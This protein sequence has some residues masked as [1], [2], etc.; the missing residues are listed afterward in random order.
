MVGLRRKHA[1]GGC[2][3]GRIGFRG[4]GTI[5]TSSRRLSAPSAAFVL[6]LSLFGLTGCAV[7]LFDTINEMV[8]FA[9]RTDKEPPTVTFTTPSHGAS[10]APVNTKISVTFSE[11]M[12]PATISVSTFS[13]ND[14]ALG[15][16]GTVQYVES[17]KMAVFTPA[18]SLNSILTYTCTVK[19]GA[20]DL[21]GN[22]IEPEYTWI[23]Q[24]GG[25]TDPAG[26]T[27]SS[28]YPANGTPDA[29]INTAVTVT[30]NESID[31]SSVDSSM[32]RLEEAGA[33]PVSGTVTY[34]D[35]SRTV[36]FEPASDL[37]P[38]K[39]HSAVVAAG[40]RDM[41][42]NT[43]APDY[44]WS[45]TT[46]ALSD[47]TPPTIVSFDPGN[48]DVDVGAGENITVDFSEFMNSDTI[49]STTLRVTTG[50]LPVTGTVSYNPSTNR[51]TFDP[52]SNLR[53]FTL[54]TVSVST[55]VKDAAGNPLSSGASWTFMTGSSDDTVTGITATIGKLEQTATDQLTA[56]VDI[57][58]QSGV[59]VPGLTRY[60]VRV[61]ESV[62]GGPYEDVPVTKVTIGTTKKGKSVAILVDTSASMSPYWANYRSMLQ[63]LI[64]NLKDFDK[65]CIVTFVNP[66]SPPA[67]A[68][69]VTVYPASGPTDNKSELIAYL[70]SIP[71]P[72]YVNSY[73]WE[74]VGRGMTNLNTGPLGVFEGLRGV[75]AFT[76]ASPTYFVGGGFW[77]E[78]ECKNYSNSEGIPI[79]SIGY[80]NASVSP[81]SVWL[82]NIATSGYF[83][84]ATDFTGLQNAHF[85]CVEIM[86]S[87]IPSNL[88]TVAWTTRAGSG[89]DVDVRITA[90]YANAFGVHTSTGTAS[91]TMQ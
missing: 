50:M 22:G 77:N 15:I 29:G 36:L 44:G 33:G 53:Y 87:M 72:N 86:E 23:F 68:A 54:Y 56:F 89:D 40:I 75:L 26:P 76:D 80:Q 8:D 47:T 48:G 88:Y 9:K 2:V 13:V 3:S 32:L 31:P 5:R 73:V 91:I 38:S 20:K 41:A 79:W 64:Q 83:L 10:G 16:S 46:A 74:G 78:D 69:S 67:G 18:T 21:N 30:F 34:I 6:L 4:F 45:F 19:K 55:D 58:D 27:V 35:S 52:Q 59:V 39:L 1:A 25:G 49:N 70:N 12:D 42:G 24:P 51:A 84:P 62:N 17:S 14:G 37:A 61:E 7:S 85:N 90:T 43:L 66:L 71:P 82:T 11:P 63:T 60:H 57:A 81:V 28:V 65:A